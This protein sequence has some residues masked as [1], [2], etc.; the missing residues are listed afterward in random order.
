MGTATS[1]SSEASEKFSRTFGLCVLLLQLV[2]IIVY[3]CVCTY[4]IHTGST[5]SADDTVLLH[6]GKFQD[7]H[8]MIFIGFGFLMTFLKRYGFYSVG[9]NFLISALTI[10]VAMVNNGFWHQL[11]YK[12]TSKAASATPG[13]DPH[14]HKIEIDILDIITGTIFLWMSW[15]SFNGALAAGDQQHRVIINTV[16]ALTGS[17]VS[18]FVISAFMRHDKK[19]DMVDIQNA[20]LAG[21]VAVGSASDLVIEPWAAILIGLIAG[22]L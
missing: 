16:I 8:V 14:W 20:T 2:L 22:T 17:C 13:M 6:Y 19:F 1:M 11:L 3:A 5:A 10:Q 18:A 7:V 21:G 12:D 15:P 4:P 9:F